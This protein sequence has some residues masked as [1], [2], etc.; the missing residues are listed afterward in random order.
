M[1][2]TAQEILDAELPEEFFRPEGSFGRVI[3]YTLS[4]H[5]DDAD[6]GKEVAVLAHARTSNFY[7]SCR[8]EIKTWPAPNHEFNIQLSVW[9]E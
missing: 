4:L 7:Q 2:R 5:D 3:H 9:Q 6:I 8:V 1:K